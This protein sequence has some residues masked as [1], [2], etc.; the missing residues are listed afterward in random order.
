[1]WP[2]MLLFLSAKTEE[3]ELLSVVEGVCS[4]HWVIYKDRAELKL[5]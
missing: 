3:C 2:G 1:M 4:D 5:S